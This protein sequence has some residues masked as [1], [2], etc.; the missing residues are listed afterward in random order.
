[1][2]YMTRE[3]MRRNENVNA[4]NAFLK[5]DLGKN[6]ELLALIDEI[7]GNRLTLYYRKNLKLYIF[8]RVM[9][10]FIEK[11]FLS[12]KKGGE[13]VVVASNLAEKICLDL[14]GQK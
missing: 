7:K 10:W 2:T 4:A 14:G 13:R 9:D 3:M 8:C 12:D 6:P 5:T 11:D 1:M